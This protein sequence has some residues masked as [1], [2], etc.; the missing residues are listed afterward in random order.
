M[1]PVVVVTGVLPKL[2][3]DV[4]LMLLALARSRWG[5]PTLRLKSSWLKMPMGP[6]SVQPVLPQDHG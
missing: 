4:K 3:V 6:W 5:R 1:A 2:Q